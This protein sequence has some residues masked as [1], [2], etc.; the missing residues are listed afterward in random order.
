M[1]LFIGI[2]LPAEIKQDIHRSLL[3]LQKSSKG[4]EDPHDYHQTLL[5]IG[6]ASPE[7]CDLVK[8]RL[9]TFKFRPFNLKP[10][11]VQFFPRRVMF[12]SFEKSPEL[13]ELK[14]RIE[15]LFPEW[16]KPHS[17]PFIP[18]VTV[19]RFQRYEYDELATG[20]SKNALQNKSFPVN[21]ICLFKSEKDAFNRK[22]HVIFKSLL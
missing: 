15:A 17:K 3:P 8:E 22:Y 21:E 19:K 4:W 2:D 14:D 13:L 20:L 7:D 18:H 11:R 16:V 10:D 12:V 1:R 6:E 5:F 9:K